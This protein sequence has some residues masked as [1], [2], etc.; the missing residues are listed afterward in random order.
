MAGNFKIIHLGMG[1]PVG[2]VVP[3][4]VFASNADAHLKIGSIRRTNEPS[5]ISSVLD[6]A[7]P[8]NTKREEWLEI[9]IRKIEAARHNLQIQVSQQQD[10]IDELKAEVKKLESL[11]QGLQDKLGSNIDTMGIMQASGP[12]LQAPEEQSTIEG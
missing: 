1:Y 10:E 7:I 2:T 3:S 9:E 5:S 11:N 12:V 8:D 4:H 6:G